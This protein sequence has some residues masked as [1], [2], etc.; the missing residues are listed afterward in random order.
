MGV[1][2]WCRGLDSS[3]QTTDYGRLFIDDKAGC[4]PCFGF[5]QHDT[6]R[7]PLHHTSNIKMVTI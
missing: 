4:L 6:C 5:A 3:R 2:K 1:D 7:T